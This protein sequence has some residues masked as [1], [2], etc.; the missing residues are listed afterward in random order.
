MPAQSLDVAAS[1]TH[2]HSTSRVVA[3]PAVHVVAAQHPRSLVEAGDRDADRRGSRRPRPAARAEAVDGQV[4]EVGVVRPARARR[5]RCRASWRSAPLRRRR[6]RVVGR[7]GE[8]AERA[9]R[10]RRRRAVADDRRRCRRSRRS[11]R[12]SSR[13]PGRSSSPTSSR[14]A[15]HVEPNP[16]SWPT[17][18]NASFCRSAFVSGGRGVV[19]SSTSGTWSSAVSCRTGRRRRTPPAANVNRA[20]TRCGTRRSAVPRPWHAQIRA[21][22][23]SISPTS[24]PSG[25][26]IG[27]VQPLATYSPTLA[28]HLVGLAGRGAAL[29][30]LV[31]HE[32][33][34]P[35]RP[36]R[37]SPA[38]SAPGRSRRA[39]PGARPTPS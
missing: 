37:G 7:V 12:S 14:N 8:A 27:H 10:R 26:R 1:H 2:S 13:T 4:G 32:R 6:R 34:W 30:D 23:S 3:D 31:G 16:S 33:G 29:H 28:T 17:P 35:P 22:V 9:R 24:G 15:V 11:G 36:P 39:A 25:Y 19:G 38:T 21:N 5:R 20:S 18:L